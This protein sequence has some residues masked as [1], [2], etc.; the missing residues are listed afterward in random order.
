MTKGFVCLN[1]NV[2]E[3]EEWKEERNQI[4]LNGK[5]IIR[6]KNLRPP[7]VYLGFE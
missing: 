3:S 1:L 7:F 5:E 4:Q 2:V 6:E